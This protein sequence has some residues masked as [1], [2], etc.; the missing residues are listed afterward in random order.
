MRWPWESFEVREYPVLIAINKELSS[1]MKLIALA[2]E[3]THYVFH[4]VYLW[5]FSQFN[6]MIQEQPGLETFIAGRLNEKWWEG[7]RNT[8][9]LRC[10]ITA[11]L[12]V[13]P[14]QVDKIL[15]P[16]DKI[17]FSTMP[18]TSDGQRLIWLM[19]HFEEGLQVGWGHA[20]QISMEGL[21]SRLQARTEPYNPEWPL[22]ERLAY[23]V[24]NRK[25]CMKSLNARES[26]INAE[27]TQI[28]SAINALAPISAPRRGTKRLL[29]RVSREAFM[30][31]I[32]SGK[33]QWAPVILE[34]PRRAEFI[35]YYP[36]MPAP[37]AK[38][39][40]DDEW[41]SWVAPM[42]APSMPLD[43]W[44]ELMAQKKK[45]LMLYPLD[46]VDLYLRSKY[47]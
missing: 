3:L 37:Y 20:E 1:K 24:F 27:L 43:E 23:C 12:F 22:L 32:K 2:H 35:G 7:Y 19:N 44:G 4:Y 9:E 16:I 6:I 36:L 34:G 38:R 10:N 17:T 8:T 14:Y 30:A 18:V 41:T 46:P 33:E 31:E 25:E 29:R 28:F 13:V 15:E 42:K 39:N 11:S 21:V 5:F 26:E 47:L 40:G 45:G